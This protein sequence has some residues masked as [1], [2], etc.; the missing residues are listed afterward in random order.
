MNIVISDAI[1]VSGV[2]V[3]LN[4]I[5]WPSGQF[6]DNEPGSQLCA[7][8]SSVNASFGFNLTPHSFQTEWVPCGDPCAF[9]GASGQLP[10][11]GH[12]LELYVGDFFFR[13]IVTHS[14]Y[15]SS[16]GGTIMNVTVEDER[17]KLRKVK[18]H[19]EDLGEDAP[20]GVVSVA[21]AFRAVNGLTDVN[22]DPSDPLIKEYRRILQFG[23]TYSQMLA[24]IDFHFN[25]GN[26]AIP[27]PDIP[28]VEQL[29]KNIGGTIEAIR[30]QFNLTNLDEAMTRVLFDTGYDWYWNMDGQRVNLINK[31]VIFDI[32]ENDILDLVSEFGSTSGLNETKQLGFGQDIVPDPTRFRVLGGHQ[33][34]F[35]NSNILSPIDGLDTSALD[36]NVVFTPAWTLLTVG[37]FDN[38]GFYRTYLPTEKELQLA[39]AGIEQWAYFKI[40]QADSTAADPPGFGL[41]SDDGVTAAQHPTFQS[42]IDPLMPLAGLATGA[43]SSGIRVISNRRDADQN[44]VLNFYARLRDHASRHY[45]RSYVVEDLIFNEASGL[46]RVVDAAWANVENQV[47]G[48]S[49][50]SSGVT[51]GGGVYVEDYEIN[52]E[53]G[54]ISP[55]VTDDFRVSAHCKLPAG[56]IY[57][58]QGDSSPASFGNWTEDAVPFNPSGDGSHYFPVS[59]SLVGQQV[60]NPRSD[61]LYAFETFPEGT[62]WCQLPVNAGPSGGLVEDNII[63]SLATLITTLNKVGGSG[64]NDI[65]NP[66]N[67]LN[68][69]DSL[70]GVAIPVQGRSRYGQSYPSTWVLGDLHFER[71]EDIQL[72]DQF[73]PWAFSPVG[74]QTSL[75]IM[76]DRAVRR[77]EGKIVPKSSSRYA[78]FQQV[79]LPL[80]SFDAFAQQNIGAS[81]LF[82]EISHGVNELNI[83]FGLDGF[84]S[85]YKIQSYFP[86]FGREAPLGERVRAQINGILNPID[87]VDLDLLDPNPSAPVN[88][89]IPDD[90]VIPPVFFDREERAVRVTINEVNNIFTLLSIPGTEDDERYRG[91][92]KHGYSKPPAAG[93]SSNPDF[94]DGAIC[95]DG[96]LN[97]NDEA[98][99]H[100]DDFEL[101]GGNTIFRYFTNGR[102]YGNGTI[103]QVERLNVDNSNLYDVTIV[104]PTATNIGNER[105]IFGVEVLNGTVAIADKTTVAVQGDAP[106]SPGTND[107]TIFINGTTSAA[108]GVTPVEIV[109]LINIG[110][111]QALSV[112][113]TLGLGSDGLYSIASGEIFTN[114]VPIP[115]REL[116]ASGDR[117]FLTTP[118]NTPSGGFGQVGPVNFVEIVR[119]AQRRFG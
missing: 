65:I 119:P 71:D 46:F 11:I 4:G 10:D 118:A 34:G 40:Y 36:G 82:G 41:P 23:G 30:F 114:V 56:T 94:V 97:I 27:I 63:S 111:S 16:A 45:G 39:L 43:A 108:A 90:P 92:D 109:S 42:R 116:A 5:A 89:L 3:P 18:I 91:I 73:V 72:D 110:T 55:F 81:G 9:H 69:Y 52:R 98:L 100:T 84:T 104:D 57:G 49:L 78:D 29:E 70:S 2:G 47:Q 35:I 96:F 74:N 7:F 64:I 24:A 76:T 95:I 14:D 31:K 107:G 15:T 77:V 85:R 67:V 106:V 54:P 62:L 117:G 1:V 60:I 88:P 48:F 12:K 32:A 22:G 17:R 13:G 115:F 33:E 51:T 19:T 101:P 105:A 59:L 61:E 37:F 87:F 86:Q 58:P 6:N 83:S 93:G 53:L 99:Y 44:W 28:T 50:S 79:G 80:L 20:S 102:P 112:C 68:V 113:K 8:L 66:A 103:V 21:R 26:A 75:Q 25:E 38:D